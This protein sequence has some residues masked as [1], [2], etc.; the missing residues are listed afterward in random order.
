MRPSDVLWSISSEGTANFDDSVRLA[1]DFR[2]TG[3]EIE[4]IFFVRALDEYAAKSRARYSAALAQIA[5]LFRKY[6][7]IGAAGEITDLAVALSDLD[8]GIVR[9]FL[10]P[11]KFSARPM[12]S[13]DVWL[14]RVQVVIAIN[15]LVRE[16]WTIRR[17][18]GHVV[19]TYPMLAKY[20]APNSENPAG[21]FAKWYSEVLANKIKH[22]AVSSAW[23]DRNDLISKVAELLAR[24]GIAASPINIGN[25]ILKDAVPLAKRAVDLGPHKG[26]KF[27]SRR[28]ARAT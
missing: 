27:L 26:S 16:N 22:P 18:C 2:A 1:I 24:Q 19:K 10:K 4:Q 21:L 12:E 8:L 9:H 23:Q 13:S 7:N 11:G 20:L 5:F 14:T 17:V 6:G 25:L 28:K 3:Q 15:Q